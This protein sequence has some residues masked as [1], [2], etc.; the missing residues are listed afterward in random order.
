V[1]DERLWLFLLFVI[2][3]YVLW[4]N[5]LLPAVDFDCFDQLTL[6]PEAETSG[7]CL[8]IIPCL[9]LNFAVILFNNQCSWSYASGW[10]N[11]D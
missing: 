7:I 2:T 6:T 8:I 4:Y 3:S 11:P 9:L 10:T 1:S 5:L